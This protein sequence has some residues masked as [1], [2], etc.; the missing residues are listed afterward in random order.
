M[1]NTSNGNSINV[2]S[3]IS[4]SSSLVASAISL[5]SCSL[6]LPSLCANIRLCVA[7]WDTRC[8]TK[9]LNGLPWVLWTPKQNL[10]KKALQNKW[11]ANVSFYHEYIIISYAGRGNSD[12]NNNSK[13]TSVCYYILV[14]STTAYSLIIHLI[15]ERKGIKMQT[16]EREKFRTVFCP[17]GALRASWSKVKHSPPA[18]SILALAVSVNLNAV[19]LIFGTS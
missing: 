15:D 18:F 4:T 6:K 9:V 16:D 11:L 1:A 17:R 12:S 14:K 5:S 7:V 3:N 8:F 10:I 19:T 2:H 13:N